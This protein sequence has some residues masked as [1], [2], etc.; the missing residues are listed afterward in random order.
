MC[1]FENEK[2]RAVTKAGQSGIQPLTFFAAEPDEREM[3]PEGA[4]KAGAGS[5][6]RSGKAVPKPELTGQ[7]GNKLRSVYNEVLSQPVPDRFL[8]LLRELDTVVAQKG[9]K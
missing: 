9:R 4:P 1:G 6:P 7:I 5:A 2:G 8:D 3:R